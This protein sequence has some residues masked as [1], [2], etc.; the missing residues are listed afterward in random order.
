LKDRETVAIAPA[1]KKEQPDRYGYQGQTSNKVHV[2]PRRTPMG[3]LKTNPCFESLS[4]RHCDSLAQT[5]R[6]E[7]GW[8]AFD[9]LSKR[10][11]APET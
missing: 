4:D 5:K 7:N 3:S 8:A 1:P 2:L 6:A 11:E 9:C 10:E